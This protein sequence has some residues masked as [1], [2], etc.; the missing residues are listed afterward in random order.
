MRGTKLCDPV[1]EKSLN[2]IFRSN[3]RSWVSNNKVV[4]CVDDDKDVGVVLRRW[5]NRASLLEKKEGSKNC[6][7]WVFIDFGGVGVIAL[8]SRVRLIIGGEFM[9]LVRMS[10]D[11]LISLK[12]WCCTSVKRV[13]SSWDVF[14]FCWGIRLITGSSVSYKSVSFKRGF[15][16]R[17]VLTLFLTGFLYLLRMRRLIER[18]RSQGE[19]I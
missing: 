7:D 17:R 15:S 6:R 18:K 3:I 2:C 8:L 1:M 10:C 4:E 9:K 11:R 16:R 14:K 5:R 12:W 13:W 19:Y